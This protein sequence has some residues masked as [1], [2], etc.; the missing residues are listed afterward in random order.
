MCV[1]VL[2]LY[3]IV[4]EMR[5]TFV[6]S[7]LRRAVKVCF[8]EVDG[9]I[10]IQTRLKKLPSSS[11]SPALIKDLYPL[12]FLAK[13]NYEHCCRRLLE[14]FVDPNVGAPTALHFSCANGNGQL[15]RSLLAWRADPNAVDGP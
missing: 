5:R 2:C 8:Q 13:H 14:C 7:T 3:S 15:V 12:S 1:P 6:F 4:E 9:A 11:S 10:A